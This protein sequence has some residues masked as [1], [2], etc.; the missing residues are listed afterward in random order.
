MLQPTKVRE[1]ALSGLSDP[2][3]RHHLSAASGLVKVGG[4]F[5]VVADDE[6]HLGAFPA[7]SDAPGSLI[8]LFPGILPAENKSRKRRKPDLEALAVLPAS[9][10]YAHAALLCVPSGSA[11]NRCTGAV[12]ALGRDGVAHDPVTF[13]LTAL[14]GRIREEIPAL[15]V[16]GA[17][18][19]G[20]DLVLMQRGN[21]RGSRNAC[22][23]LHLSD[24]LASLRSAIPLDAR[25]PPTIEYVDLGDVDGVPLCFSDVSALPGVGLVF[26]AIAE[27]TDDSYLDGPCVG[28]AIGI[29]DPSGH[30]GHLERVAGAPKIEGIH[31]ELV[32][33]MLKLWLVTDAD[34]E[35]LPGQ[36]LTA[37]LCIG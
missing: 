22:I 27:D 31:A 13:D 21:H 14:Y 30:V 5:Y 32:G 7:D 33:Q 8:R 19:I 24:V 34:D 1:L 3:R 4:F 16:E 20:D 15:N 9:T 6:N 28:A 35:G 10:E 29:I 25:T 26:A 2:A 12:L 18:M 37:E 17:T 36:L 11:P 23:R